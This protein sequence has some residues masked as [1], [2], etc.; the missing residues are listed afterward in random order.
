VLFSFN[1]LHKADVGIVLIIV[2][3]LL[4]VDRTVKSILIDLQIYKRVLDVTCKLLQ[5][6]MSFLYLLRQCVLH[7]IL[8][9]KTLL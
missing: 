7:N 2:Y 1:L 5:L 4:F 9:L 8:L 6:L 3:F